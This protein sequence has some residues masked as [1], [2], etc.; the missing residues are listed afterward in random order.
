LSNWLTG[1]LPNNAARLPKQ[2]SP[3]NS[4]PDGG[5]AAQAPGIFSHSLSVISVGLQT[6]VSARCRMHH[7]KPLPVSGE[8]LYARC[9]FYLVKLNIP[10]Q[11]PL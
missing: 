3:A 4:A 6:Q 8:W 5:R 1:I 2:N 9:N 7:K 11:T 10:V